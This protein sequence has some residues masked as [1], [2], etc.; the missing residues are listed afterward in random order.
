MENCPLC[1]S[2]LHVYDSSVFNRSIK[3]CSCGYTDIGEVDADIGIMDEIQ[4]GAKLFAEK[5]KEYPKN[6]EYNR[7]IEEYLKTTKTSR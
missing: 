6:R 3:F 4:E 1:G 2:D 7:E 5:L